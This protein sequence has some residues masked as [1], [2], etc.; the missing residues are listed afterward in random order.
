MSEFSPL[1]KEKLKKMLLKDCKILLGVTGSVAAIKV[2]HLVKL[3]MEQ[4]ALV[5][6][7]STQNAIHFIPADYLC[8]N[9]RFENIVDAQ[10]CL[11]IP[12]LHEPIPVYTDADEWILWKKRG[13][14]VLHIKLMQWANLFVIA[15]L[16]ANTLSKMAYG[17]CDNLLTCI[18]RAFDQVKPIIVCPAMNT[19]MWMHPI[20][21]KSLNLIQSMWRLTT[22][23]APVEKTLIC[24]DTGNMFRLRVILCLYIHEIQ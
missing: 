18:L 24:G 23:M 3:Y 2:V 12:E 20:T 7:V 22:I 16:N 17:L 6:V 11:S 10:L 1:E 15:P 5:K 8:E 4:G 9:E 13:D 14:P 21:E 19:H